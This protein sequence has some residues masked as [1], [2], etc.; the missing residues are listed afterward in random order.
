MDDPIGIKDKL[1]YAKNALC[2]LD[3]CGGAYLLLFSRC[4]NVLA[5]HLL[6]TYRLLIFPLLFYG[7]VP[8]QKDAKTFLGCVQLRAASRFEQKKLGHSMARAN[9]I[10]SKFFLTS[11]TTASKYIPKEDQNPHQLKSLLSD[12]TS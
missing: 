12:L 5:F 9:L 11:T 8:L 6:N 1:G 7:A 2:L 4:K 10:K 3:G